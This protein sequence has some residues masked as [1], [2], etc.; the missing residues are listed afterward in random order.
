ME[1]FFCSKLSF[2]TCWYDE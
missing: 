1:C 2:I